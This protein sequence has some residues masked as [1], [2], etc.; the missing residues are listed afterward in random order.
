MR[1]QRTLVVQST[2]SV[3]FL[4][5]VDPLPYIPNNKNEC[6]GVVELVTMSPCHGEGR[7]FESLRSRHFWAFLSRLDN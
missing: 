6:G 7:G 4:D 1:K 2:I 5:C 3:N